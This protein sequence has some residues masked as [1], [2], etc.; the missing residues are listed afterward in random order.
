MMAAWVWMFSNSGSTFVYKP[1]VYQ[2]IQY[3]TCWLSYSIQATYEHRQELDSQFFIELDCSAT[4]V[5]VH[6]HKCGLSRWHQEA[7]HSMRVTVTVQ[8]CEKERQGHNELPD[9]AKSER[10]WPHPSQPSMD[11]IRCRNNK[12]DNPL[13]KHR[14]QG[15]KIATTVA[16][17]E[18]FPVI[19]LHHVL[20]Q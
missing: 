8:S 13:R 11:S 9:T 2:H 16:G 12:L 6:S 5:F 20:N 7:K 10:R 19:I 3:L 18:G 17:I 15:C 1:I 4:F 14:C